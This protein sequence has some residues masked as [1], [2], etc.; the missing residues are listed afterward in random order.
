M[1]EGSIAATAAGIRQSQPALSARRWWGLALLLSGSFVTVLDVFIVNVAIPRIRADLAASFAEVELVIAVYALAYA[2]SLVTGGRLGDIH[3]RR[4]MFMLGMAG[5]TLASALCGLA[6]TPVA[7]IA[8]RL[9]QGVTAAMLF[10][11]VLAIIRVSFEGDDR[12][13]AFGA[14]GVVL[15][16]SAIAGQ[17]LGGFLVEHAPWG[18]G[19][20]AVFL[21]NL[22][23]A[24]V[25]LPLA[26]RLIPESRAEGAVR[27]DLPGA[28][29]AALGLGLAVY[30]LVEGR[31]AGWPLW[32]FASLAAAVPVLALFVWFERRTA[33]RGGAPVIDVAL[34]GN[35]GFAA[36]V[37]LF[38]VFYSTLNSFFLA[39]AL[40]LQLGLGL[41]PFAAGSVMAPSAVVFA[42]MS[43]QAGRV[44]ARFGTAALEAGAL[45]CA[46][47]FALVA[48]YV[49]WS[50]AA[51]DP[52]AL[53]LLMTV[54]GAGSGLLMTP[55]LNVVLSTVEARHAGMA[56]GAVST[57]QQVG[58]AL[59]IAVVG[60]IFFGTL[61][62][63]AALGA[64]PGAGAYAHAY[65]TALGYNLAATALVW[66]LLRRLRAPARTAAPA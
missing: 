59:G 22:P 28:A 47:A 12:R 8:A 16:S 61:D 29:L 36:G 65:A 52:V 4:R 41:G 31:Q 48:G 53:A 24:L 64:G 45:A 5:F 43:V 19:W 30:P 60:A 17:L 54:F 27:L 62:A 51:S 23:L 39:N 7:L 6:P 10:P 3:G 40:L 32:A 1:P 42:V 35:R 25:V 13:R 33:A 37:V 56:S 21:V 50:G 44:V 55:L 58:G 2:V 11:Q 66:A 9:V 26:G 14:M 20:R 15:G 57:M 18:L 38:L 34:F 46:A 49:G 63:A